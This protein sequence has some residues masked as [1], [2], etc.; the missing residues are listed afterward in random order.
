V[1]ID[2]DIIVVG[3]PGHDFN[4]KYINTS[5]SFIRKEFNEEFYIPQRIVTDLGSSGIRLQNSGTVL[6]NNG[7]IFTFENKIIDWST[8]DKK[9]TFVEKIVPVSGCDN[10]NFGST[11]AIDRLFRTDADY[12]IFA[13]STSGI[14]SSGS[15]YSYDIMLRQPPPSIPSPEA[16]IQAK[17]FGE[18][19][20]AG[21]PS[22]FISIQ[23]SGEN[24][25][26][27]FTSG[28]IF[29]DNKGQIF[30]EVS[31]Q[32]PATKGF[33]AHRPFIK[34]VDGQYAFGTQNNNNIINC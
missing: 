13:G 30:I 19:D 29:S 34:S 24:N 28:T 32:D 16:F 6:L 1:D 4:N 33:I 18:R 14:Y 20:S 8:K 17:V 15:S 7:S 9:W 25:Q 11:V 2:S 31:G 3:A 23:N 5:G 22:V 12:T 10:Q 26:K 21:N 27:Y